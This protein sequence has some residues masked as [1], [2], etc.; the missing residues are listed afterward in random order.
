[1]YT[2]SIDFNNDVFSAD[3]LKRLRAYRAAVQAGFYNEGGTDT[4]GLSI[5]ALLDEAGW[6]IAPGESGR[7]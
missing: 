7:H 5:E 6:R 4:P 3:Q 1:M 2:E